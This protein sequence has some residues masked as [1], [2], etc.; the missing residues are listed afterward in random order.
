[1]A[2]GQITTSSG[3][4]LNLTPDR[5]WVNG[6]G[7]QLVPG[8]GQMSL[9]DLVGGGGQQA[10]PDYSAPIDVYG[11]K[12]YRIKGD[13][14]GVLLADGRKVTLEQNPDLTAARQMQALN[15]EKAQLSNKLMEAQIRAAGQRET[16]SMQHVETPNGPMAFNPKTGQY[17]PIAM[18][19]GVPMQ[20]KEQAQRSQDANSVMELTDQAAPLL[21]Q[22]PGS[23]AGAALNQLGRVVGLNTDASKAQASLD[24]LAGSL[25]AKMPKMSGPQ[26]DK[27]V[28]L[29]KAMA[30]NLNDPTL[31]TEAKQ[32]AM[33]T[34]RLL[35]QKYATGYQGQAQPTQQPQR[36]GAMK[37]GTVEDGHMYLG[38]DPASPASWKVV[39]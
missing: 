32:A 22:A 11:Q 3:R 20:S 33:K 17:T 35:N 19:G 6:A 24:V 16:P 15:M 12:G 26:S 5:G 4:T 28:A 27:D 1:M 25:I 13:P 7:Q 10:M 21:E 30:G 9:A 37:P 34:L 31:P 39:Q 8:S 29:Y 23:Y 14:G 36:T 18:P 38:G 2:Y